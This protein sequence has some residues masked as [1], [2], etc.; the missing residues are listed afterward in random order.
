MKASVLYAVLFAFTQGVGIAA[1]PK[2]KAGQDFII[3]IDASRSMNGFAPQL[4]KQKFRP[5]QTAVV[6]ILQGIPEANH[7]VYLHFFNDGTK[8]QFREFT[9][10]AGGKDKA[11]AIAFVGRYQEFIAGHSTH[12]WSSF[13]KALRFG[14]ANGYFKTAKNGRAA[15]YPAVYLFTYIHHDD[16]REGGW[17][18]KKDPKQPNKPVI[19]D[20]HPW[21]LQLINNPR[22]KRFHNLDVLK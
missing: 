7:R 15:T 17:V 18:G 14:E 5:V 9:F 10:K 1:P 4:R 22:W 12:L 2:A 8:E 13:H 3:V 21:L 19:L 20:A 11:E 6:Q 16:Q